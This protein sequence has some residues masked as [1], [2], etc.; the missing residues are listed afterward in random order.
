MEN[1]L[2]LWWRVYV[3]FVLGLLACVSGRRLRMYRFGR[4][5]FNLNI[6]HYYVQAIK[7]PISTILGASI[8]SFWFLFFLFWQSQ[9]PLPHDHLF[10]HVYFW[11]VFQ[12][13]VHDWPRVEKSASI[14]YFKCAVYINGQSNSNFGHFVA[15]LG[16]KW[17]HFGI[18][19]RL[20]LH[21]S[22]KSGSWGLFWRFE[23]SKS[24]KNGIFRRNKLYFGNFSGFV[25]HFDKFLELRKPK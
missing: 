3:D 5:L 25:L 7:S 17:G 4:Q 11:K 19:D 9:R 15:L 6:C 2:W 8:F 12:P 13:I 23:G 1:L 14:Y 10:Y 18:V 22:C 16:Y 20:F 24:Y 21:L